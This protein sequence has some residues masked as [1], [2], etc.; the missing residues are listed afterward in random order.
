VRAGKG[1]RT[2]TKKRRHVERNFRWK[3]L[4]HTFASWLRRKGEELGTIGALLG[5]REGSRMTFRYA[6]LTEGHKHEAVRRLEGL[7]RTPLL[8]TTDPTTDPRAS[9]ANT[10]ASIH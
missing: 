8:P 4:R 1:F 3:D 10:T 7:I 9:R 6:H 2:I 5:H